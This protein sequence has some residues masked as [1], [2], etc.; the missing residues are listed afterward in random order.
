[1][2]SGPQLEVARTSSAA[3]RRVWLADGGADLGEVAQDEW[4]RVREKCVVTGTA[5]PLRT[6]AVQATETII[7]PPWELSAGRHLRRADPSRCR[8]TLR[9][10]ARRTRCWRR[11]CRERASRL[12]AAA[13]VDCGWL[14]TAV[15]YEDHDPIRQRR[16]W[17]RGRMSCENRPAAIA[18]M[19]LHGD[20]LAA[21]RRWRDPGHSVP[22]VR[23]DWRA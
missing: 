20:V 23:S 14:T 8:P 13:F 10:R 5:I 22:C 18:P 7:S 11:G 6:P 1:M 15:T 12:R 16:Q 19:T 3:Q 4:P 2:W 17:A 9:V 21:G